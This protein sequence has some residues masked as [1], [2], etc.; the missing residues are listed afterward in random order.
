MKNYFRN[1]FIV[2]VFVFSVIITAC[3]FFKDP[4]GSAELLSVYSSQSE[5]KFENKTEYVR[6]LNATL[7]ITNTGS[8]D[9][10]NSTVS[11]QAETDK[12]TYYKTL[13]FDIIIKPSS[14]IFIPVQFDF[15]THINGSSSEKWKDNSM[16]IIEVS[17]K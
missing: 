12:R 9:I 10:Y 17:W 16:K 7:K 14:N 1:I 4:Q 3:S 15:D 11:I 8:I 5:Y 2:I 6:Y 13:S